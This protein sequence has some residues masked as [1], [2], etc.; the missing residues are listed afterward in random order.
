MEGLPNGRIG[1]SP[2]RFG[3]AGDPSSPKAK[4]DIT[5]SRLAMRVSIEQVGMVRAMR[6]DIELSRRRK[7]ENDL[8]GP[9]DQ[10]GKQGAQ[11]DGPK[12]SP[13]PDQEDLDPRDKGPERT[14]NKPET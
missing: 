8:P 10:G 3:S 5:E 7:E 1:D 4:Y 9:Q 14:D 6:R 11:K 2:R 12:P 13:Q